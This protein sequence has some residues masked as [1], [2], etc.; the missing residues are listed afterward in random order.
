MVEGRRGQGGE[1]QAEI[2]DEDARRRGDNL[3]AG[4]GITGH[5]WHAS[6]FPGRADWRLLVGGGI[7]PIVVTESCYIMLLRKVGQKN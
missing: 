1:C 2:P 7:K 5:N 6:G 3:W 4:G